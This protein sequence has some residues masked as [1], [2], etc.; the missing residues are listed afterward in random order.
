MADVPQITIVNGIPTAGSG[1]VETISTTNALLGAVGET[2]P[3]TDIASAGHNGRLQRIAQRI[4]ALI[5]QLPATLGIKVAAN[6]LCITHASDDSVLAAIVA[7]TMPVNNGTAALAGRMTIA[8]DSTGI[9]GTKEIEATFATLTR[10]A[11]GSGGTTTYTIGDSIS[12]HATAGSVTAL[13]SGNF[14][15]TNDHP[16]A[17]EELLL[18]TTDTTFGNVLNVTAVASGTL[19]VGQPITGS[20]IPASSVIAS[21]VT[22]T[23]G[24]IGVY[25]LSNRASAYAA[26]T[27]VTSVGGVLTV[28]K[29]ASVCAVAP[30]RPELLAGFDRRE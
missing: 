11:A 26:S 30:T 8:S 3:A 23:V 4:S 9:V 21:Q 20:G 27:T 15:D 22:G 1:T 29:C 17:I 5:L 7:G 6:A 12:N 19:A 24:G 25:T 2:A 14:S 13:V 10:P 16:V 18:Q 28:F